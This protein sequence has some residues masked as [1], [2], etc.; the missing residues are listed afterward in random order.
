MTL[1]ERYMSRKFLF[2]LL[3]FLTSI[4][5]LANKTMTAD[6]WIGLTEWTLGLYIA[7]NVGTKVATTVSAPK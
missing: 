6:Q 4:G 5:F 7:G 3:V 1:D 2:A